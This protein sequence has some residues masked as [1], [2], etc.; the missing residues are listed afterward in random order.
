MCQTDL[1]ARCVLDL[2]VCGAVLV[3]IDENFLFLTA[4]PASPAWLVA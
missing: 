2:D 4:T 1:W 3:Q